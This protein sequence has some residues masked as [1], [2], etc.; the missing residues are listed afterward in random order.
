VQE[1]KGQNTRLIEFFRKPDTIEKLIAFLVDPP[2]PMS[3]A[4]RRFKYP[5]S[6][7]EVLCCE[8]CLGLSRREGFESGKVYRSYVAV[9]AKNGQ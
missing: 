6:A 3:D 4:K 9:L 1:T 8:V 7:C 5:Y 2:A